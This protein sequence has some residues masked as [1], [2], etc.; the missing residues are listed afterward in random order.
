MFSG[1][2][3]GLGAVSELNQHG[4][5]LSI[6]VDMGDL[7][8]EKLSIGDSIAVN[9]VCLTVV[10]FVNGNTRFDVSTETLSRSLLGDLRVG[11]KV[12]LELAMQADSRF[13]GHI[14]SGH[15]DGM[16]CLIGKSPAERS[17]RMTFSVSRQLGK[18]V[19]EKSSV[20]IDGVSLTVNQVSDEAGQTQFDVNIV[21]HTL[22]VTTLGQLDIGQ[23]VHIEVDMIARYVERLLD[24][25]KTPASASDRISS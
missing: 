20:C 23:Q 15:V 21:P 3:Q 16:G 9:G 24:S 18:Y 5:D 6:V 11:Q 13:G 1:I 14:V 7:S 8:K 19:A 12:N 2:V 4:Q 17:M 22:R 10:Q 25:R